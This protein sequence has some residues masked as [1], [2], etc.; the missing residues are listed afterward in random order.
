VA[1]INSNPLQRMAIPHRHRQAQF[2]WL[3]S[4]F[5]ILSAA[6]GWADLAMETETARILAPG[7]FEISTAFEFQTGPGGKEYALPMAIEVGLYHHLELLIEPV[8]ITSIQPKGGEAA[9]GVGDL[10]TTLTYLV[11]EEK[12]Y[13]PA[14][15]LATE[16][17]FPTAGNTQIGSGEYDYRIYAVASKRLGPL[18][19]HVNL[20]YNIVGS[21]PGADTKNPIDIEAG[22]E[23]FVHPTFNLFSEI[24]YIGSS[25][26]SAGEGSGA[27]AVRQ[28]APA[29]ST[30][31]AAGTPEIAGEEIVGTVGVRVH[32]TH[33]MDV[34]TSFSYDNNSAK[35]FRTGVTIKY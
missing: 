27:A 28:L 32:A 23:W 30:D 34:Y 9:T 21:P 31:G 11:I 8:P 3:F 2:R 7:H 16:I 4:T 29:D 13:V 19:L 17:K 10:E 15:A 6:N 14:V 24:N 22:V 35:L 1:I 25:I 18:D 33:Y 26:G 5:F 12:K 20:G